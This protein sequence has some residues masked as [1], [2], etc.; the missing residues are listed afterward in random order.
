M[1]REVRSSRGALEP[2]DLD[3]GALKAGEQV[4]VRT[5]NSIYRLVVLCPTE[6][7]VL[8]RGGNF[9]RSSIEATLLGS[10]SMQ[11]FQVGRIARRSSLKILANG[12][13]YITSP[14]EAIECEPRKR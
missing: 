14:V 10:S 3:I 8:I 5:R 11:K 9:F 6:R 7:K 12:C 2:S 1:T 4:T 13:G